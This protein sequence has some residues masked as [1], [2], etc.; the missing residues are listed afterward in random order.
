MEAIMNFIKKLG[1]INSSILT[2]LFFAASF[3]AHAHGGDQ[4]GPHKGHIRMPGAFHTE[5]VLKD[6]SMRVYLLDIK[7]QN[8]TTKDS[9]VDVK[10]IPSGKKESSVKCAE[11]DTFYTC[12]LPKGFAED[13]G[14][15]TIRAQRSKVRGSVARYNLPLSFK[16]TGDEHE[17]HH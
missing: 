1:C 12:E 5:L 17:G 13:S 4:P 15:I 10:Y 6:G 14:A 3:N 2:T 7:F 8:P 9:S 16:K 11:D